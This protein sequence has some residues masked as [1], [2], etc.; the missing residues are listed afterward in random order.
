MP[1]QKTY[2]KNLIL[3]GLMCSL[4]FFG[5][6]SEADGGPNG[7]DAGAD[8]DTDT[9][10]DTDTDSDTDTGADGDS[11]TDT[12]S[13]SDAD[14]DTDSDSDSDTDGDT[15]ADSD[16]DSDADADSDSDSDSDVNSV[17]VA[18]IEEPEN[19][20]YFKAG[21][22]IEFVGSGTDI[23]DGALTG[24]ALTWKA[25][26]AAFGTGETVSHS[27]SAGD[28]VISLEAKDSQ[29]AV[30]KAAIIIH[31]VS[32]LPPEC[33]ILEPDDGDSFEEGQTVYFQAECT[34]PEGETIDPNKIVWTSSL[35]GPLGT[36]STTQATLNN[37]GSHD[38]EVCAEDPTDPN[39][40]GCDEIS[41]FVIVD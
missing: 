35:E 40:D 3:V 31:V 24:A 4:P 38:I 28:H 7:D 11:D 1:S 26:S 32:N 5:C 25:G 16:A 41:I 39:L 29:G 12:D 30:G 9:D 13:D 19:G 10:T 22:A 14:S 21:D 33:V 2:L 34:D 17:P 8:S 6:G 18:E 36:G 27:L 15:D 23:E 37:V 20:D